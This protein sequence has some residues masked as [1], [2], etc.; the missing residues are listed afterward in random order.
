METEL[1]N[2][3]FQ[4]TKQDVRITDLREKF[5]ANNITLNRARLKHQATLNKMR[6]IRIDLHNASGLIHDSMKLRSCVKV[7]Q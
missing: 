2:L 1:E 7:S 4:T 5:I 3:Q 6:M